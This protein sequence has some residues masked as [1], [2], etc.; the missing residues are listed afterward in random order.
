MLERWAAWPRGTRWVLGGTA[1]VLVVLAA[2]WVLFVPAADWL[3][4][5]DVGSVTGPL[6]TFR[7]QT[8]RDAAR[9]RLLTLGAG[10]LA[11]TALVY[12]ARTL[13]LSRQGQV[14]D[15]YNKAIE[16]L[17]SDKLDVRIGAVYAL[18][19]IARDSATDHPTVMEVLAAFIREHSR[20]QWPRAEP[21]AEAPEQTTR[22]DVQA[23]LTVLGRRDSKRDVRRIDLS[24]ANL[25]RAN[26]AGADLTRMVLQ[27][28]D[29]G[30][31][32]LTGANLARAKLDKADLGKVLIPGASFVGAELWSA[33]LAG[34]FF[35]GWYDDFGRTSP[36]PDFT[37]TDMTFALW[38]H[39]YPA[40][41]GWARNPD[42]GQLSRTQRRRRH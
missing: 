30:Q 3:A 33:N 29:L 5:H 41:E 32:D 7:L 26:L 4:T 38:P 13:H 16:H 20:E 24:G 37:G 8:A 14:T 1:A 19:R 35:A 12:T 40:P 9:G 11:A 2:T 22:P 31:T 10:F 42:S 39:I 21:G 18:E 28:T 25:R 36:P 17:G 27:Q 6:R 15:R 23:A 34:A